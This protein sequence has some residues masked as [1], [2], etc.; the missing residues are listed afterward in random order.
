MSQNFIINPL[1]ISYESIKGDL[2]NYITA[3]PEQDGW[4]DYFATSAGTA[5]IELIAALGAFYIYHFIMGRRESYLSTCNNYS[6]ALGSAEDSGYSASRGINSIV[7]LKIIPNT[8]ANVLKVF[9]LP[10]LF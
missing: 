5:I 9:T 1:S 6:S 2:L 8:S 10:M 7:K 4:A 3:K